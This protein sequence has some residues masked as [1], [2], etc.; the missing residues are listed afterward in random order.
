MAGF[1]GY[2]A[3][4]TIGGDVIAN[5][6]QIGDID[7]S[8]NDIDVTDHDSLDAI[9]EYV[10]GL[11]E[12]GEVPIEG[13]FNFAVAQLMLTK[14]RARENE[15]CVITLPTTP[16]TTFTFQGY[17]KGWGFGAPHD[18]KIPFSGAIKINGAPTLATA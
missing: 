17:V 6:T 4:L 18:D 11:I 13:N 3:T 16:A 5:L 14:L 12:P 15:E 2:G 1:P 9:M 7:M 8:T 10:P